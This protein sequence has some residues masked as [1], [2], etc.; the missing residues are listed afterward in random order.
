VGH[1]H[2]AAP[3][4]LLFRFLRKQRRSF[5]EQPTVRYGSGTARFTPL[6]LTF[7]CLN[8]S[9]N[10]ESILIMA[11]SLRSSSCDSRES[12]SSLSCMTTMLGHITSSWLFLLQGLLVAS[13]T[14]VLSNTRAFG[15]PQTES[16]VCAIVK[17]EY[18][19]GYADCRIGIWNKKT[20]LV[21]DRDLEG[22]FFL[23]SGSS[24]H[25]LSVGRRN[26]RTIS[27]SCQFLATRCLI[28]YR[29]KRIYH[30]FTV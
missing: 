3:F 26:K 17:P 22:H 6:L 19:I 7:L 20:R 23:W 30:L 24:S 2:L 9:D 29:T 4:F 27:N 15:P 28:K 11:S 18:T 21:F 10:M 14:Q 8:I 1:L 12:S 25:K 13:T 16:R 5:A